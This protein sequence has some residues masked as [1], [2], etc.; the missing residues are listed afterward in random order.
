MNK[1]HLIS[2]L[3]TLVLIQILGYVSINYLGDYGW[4]VFLFI[5]FLI[6]FL[7][8]YISGKK[9]T[10]TKSM[11]YRLSFAALGIACLVLLVFAIEGIICLLMASPLLALA[12]WLGSYIGYKSTGSNFMNSKNT[13]IILVLLSLGFTGFDYNNKPKDL[14]PVRTKI[15]VNAPIEAV[16]K[17]VVTFDKINEPTDWIFTTGI[18]YPTDATIV[19]KGVGA[20][21]Y[22]NFTTGSFIEPITTWNEPNLLQ[23]DVQEQPIPMNELNPFWNVHPPHLDG[24]FKS[25]KGQFKLTKISKNKTELEG[26]TW[27]KVDIYPEIYWKGW[28]NFIVHRIHERVLNHIKYESE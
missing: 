4:S 10:I 11:A 5:P 1:I 22:C 15:I 25:Y 9:I 7:P 19:G 2:I 23:F 24:Y 20:I 12:V 16:W 8:P 26:T 3:I 14:I 28:S 13:T 6:G 21:R 18:A 17:N 27:Y